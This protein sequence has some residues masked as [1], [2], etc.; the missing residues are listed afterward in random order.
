MAQ[1]WILKGISSD[2]KQVEVVTRETGIIESFKPETG[3]LEPLPYLLEGFD[4]PQDGEAATPISY[5][6]QPKVSYDKA[7]T[8]GASVAGLMPYFIIGGYDWLLELQSMSFVPLLS[9]QSGAKT[10]GS[11]A[12]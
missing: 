12:T 1:R 2:G 5:G 3:V 4:L 11:P 7:T 9:D 10:D 6:R 8:Q